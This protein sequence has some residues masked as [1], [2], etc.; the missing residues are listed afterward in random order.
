MSTHEIPD[1]PVWTAALEI[2]RGDDRIT[3]Q[4]EGFLNLAVAQGVMG[5]TLYLDVPNELTAAQIN[6]RMRAPILEALAH[7]EDGSGESVS[8]FRVVVNPDLAE[9]HLT[10]V[11][12]LAAPPAASVH[13]A[14]EE[15]VESTNT[16]SRTDTRLNPKYTFENFVINFRPALREN[17][18]RRTV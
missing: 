1:V 14:A 12:P 5:G 16:S 3:P 13:R 11:L 17:P 7:A 4:L 6:K 8:A 15:P 10:A 2:M 18:F 9:S